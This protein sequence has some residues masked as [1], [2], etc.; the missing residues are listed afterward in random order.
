MLKLTLLLIVLWFPALLSGLEDAGNFYYWRYQLIML[1]GI[2]GTGYMG[3]ASLL[4]V[5]FT[6]TEKLVKG[7]DKGYAIHKKL[8]I[9]AAVALIAHWL[10]IK[11]AKWLIA[12]GWIEKRVHHHRE[13]EGINWHSLAKDTG[14]YTFYILL[15]FVL[16]SLISLISYRQFKYIHKVA[17]LLMIAGAFHSV[18]F[19]DWSLPSAGI[20][21]VIVMICVAGVGSALLSLSGRIG[22]RKKVSGE[23]THVERFV[24]DGGE[25]RVIH[26]IVQL[27][28][29]LRYR[30]GQFCYLNFHDGESPHPFSVLNYD[31]LG[32]RLEFAVKELGDYTRNMVETLKTGQPVTVEGGYGHF[33]IPET[34]HQVWVGAGIGI[35]PFISRLYWLNRQAG[36]QKRPELIHLF[37]C[38]RAEKEAFFIKEIKRLTDQLDYIQLHLSDADKGVFL[39]APDIT[40]KMAG[41]SFDVSFCGPDSFGRQLAE[42]LQ[43]WGLPAS[44]FQRELFKMR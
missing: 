8:G 11:S 21:A 28:S 1:T 26:F 5:R 15:V 22:S 6:W 39:S 20:D 30:E 41:K 42:A 43:Q 40:E 24:P 10:L 17:G 16:I 23:V 3:I 25:N 36:R 19:L 13:V 44:A 32:N 27:T 35:V 29:S 14:E 31:P 37:Y 18:F 38:V 34:D 9:G 4:A 2:I 7:L 33:Q 12:A